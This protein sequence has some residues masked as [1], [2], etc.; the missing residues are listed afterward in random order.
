M[1]ADRAVAAP[2]GWIAHSLA[3]VAAAAGTP[4]FF[5]PRLISYRLAAAA[6]AAP[7]AAP[8]ARPAVAPG[9]RVAV[10]PVSP[11]APD[12]PAMV[13]AAAR[14]RRAGQVA[15]VVLAQTVLRAP[16][17]PAVLAQE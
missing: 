13:A 11:E 16:P 10:P 6:A 1:S 4:L 3:V 2:K 5:A 15:P 12:L 8:P 17:T 14:H 7:P 9:V